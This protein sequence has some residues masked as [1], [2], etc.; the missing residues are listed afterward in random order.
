M[1]C[2]EKLEVFFTHMV[3]IFG[4]RGNPAEYADN[5]MLGIESAARIC[6]GIEV[7]FRRCGSGEL[8]LAH[9]PDVDGHVIVE[10]PLEDLRSLGLVPARDLF[11]ADLDADLDLEVKNW[12]FDPGFEPD[13]AIGFEVAASARARDIVTSF[14]WQTID[15]VKQS[16]PGVTTGLLF[17]GS[18]AWEAAIVHARENHH[19]VIAP[20]H[21]LVDADLVNAAHADGLEVATWT[22]DDLSEITRLVELGVNTIITNQPARVVEWIQKGQ[23]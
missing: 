11:A 10:T 23:P 19:A 17:E 9:D 1:N 5:S 6:D 2:N 7:D 15:A 16:Y 21:V 18:V 4:H 12:P 13:F 8:V 14:H 20:H 22:A 3:K